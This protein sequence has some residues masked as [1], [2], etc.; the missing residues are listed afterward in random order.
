[1]GVITAVF[2]QLV[3]DTL[4]KLIL[5]KSRLCSVTDCAITCS[6]QSRWSNDKA[7]VEGKS[8]RRASAVSVIPKEEKKEV[9]KAKKRRLFVTRGNYVESRGQTHKLVMLYK[10]L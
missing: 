6:P 10:L 7:A 9:L 4:Y 5:I 3:L 8:I 2:L 1:M